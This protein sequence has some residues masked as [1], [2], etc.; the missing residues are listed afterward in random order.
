VH[1]YLRIHLAPIFKCFEDPLVKQARASLKIVQADRQLQATTT[2][3][4]F[5]VDMILF[6]K[7]RVFDVARSLRDEATVLALQLQYTCLNRVSEL[8][9]TAGDHYMRADDVLFEMQGP[10]T[11]THEHPADTYLLTVDRLRA[12]ILTTRSAKN[13]QVGAGS[14]M[15]VEVQDTSSPDVAFCL[16]TD[17]FRWSQKACPRGDESFLS[18]RNKWMLEP[19]EYNKNIQRVAHRMGLDHR[20]FTSHSLR[21]GGAS[22]LAAAGM[23]DWFIKKMG[24]WKSLAF[25]QYIQ[26]AKSSIRAAVKVL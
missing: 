21:I 23:P 20:R 11:L 1:H 4:A 24:R 26:F 15:Y 9:P 10:D 3:L 17:A 12:V 7:E 2:R 5:T 25:L 14:R 16:A 19:S 6:G 13:D 18:Y 22:A 8:L